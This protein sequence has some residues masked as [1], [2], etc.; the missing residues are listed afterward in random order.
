MSQNPESHTPSPQKFT[1]IVTRLAKLFGLRPVRL[2]I[3]LGLAIVL[4][5]LLTVVILLW[6]TGTVKSYVLDPLYQ[7]SR[8][9]VIIA[10]AKIVQ[11]KEVPP[12]HRRNST[13]TDKNNVAFSR[14]R[15]GTYIQ[16]F[17]YDT[18]MESV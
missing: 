12:E 11:E 4:P 9:V 2:A 17:V 10:T 13:Y 8:Y 16:S 6:I 7:T 3:W 18:V 5:P 1:E 15:D 14:V